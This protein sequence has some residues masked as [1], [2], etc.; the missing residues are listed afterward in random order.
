MP[1]RALAAGLMITAACAALACDSDDVGKACSLDGQPT[2]VPDPV[3]GEVPVVELTRIHRDSECE[4]FQC[5]THAGLSSYCTRRCEMESAGN[6]KSCSTDSNCTEG[7]CLDGQCRDDDCPKGFWCKQIQEAGPLAENR[8]CV[9]RSGC[10]DN[11]QCENLGEIECRQV[12]CFDACCLSSRTCDFDPDLA[13]ESGC[14]FHRLVCL[15]WDDLG[16]IC[17]EDDQDSDCQCQPTS[18]GTPWVGPVEQRG[19]CLPIEE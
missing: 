16:C 2:F 13:D 3:S 8:Y 14:E 5:L 11:F 18:G 7:Y 4:T 12:G 17:P 19:V 6:A 1:N 10:E 15:P 9:R